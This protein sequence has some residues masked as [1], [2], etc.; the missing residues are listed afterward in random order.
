MAGQAQLEPMNASP[1]HAKVKVSLQLADSMYVAGNAITGKVQLECKA[2]KGLGIGVVM[3]ELYAVEG[4][5]RV[6]LG[7]LQ[8]AHGPQS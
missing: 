4:L 7:L 6:Q 2:D 1:H 3:V 8:L 5:C